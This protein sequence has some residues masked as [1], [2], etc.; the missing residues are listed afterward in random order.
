MY[1]QEAIKEILKRSIS[2]YIDSE[3]NSD[4]G[5]IIVA[6]PKADSMFF[7]EAMENDKF[8]LL[9]QLPYFKRYS[10]NLHTEWEIHE[11]EDCTKLIFTFENFGVFD[12]R[13]IL[14]VKEPE[15]DSVDSMEFAKM[16]FGRKS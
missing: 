4:S 10:I 8:P 15:I 12:F 6:V 7:K 1:N 3:V 5:S 11:C 13:S 14:E 16:I 2:G 9:N